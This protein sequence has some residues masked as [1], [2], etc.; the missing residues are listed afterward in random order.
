MNLKKNGKGQRVPSFG[1][2]LYPSILPK[3]FHQNSCFQQEHTMW[4]H[5][6]I[7]KIMIPHIGQFFP[8]QTSLK[9]DNVLLII[10]WQRLPYKVGSFH[11]YSHFAHTRFLLHLWILMKPLYCQSSFGHLRISSEWEIKRS[12]YLFMYIFNFI[13]IQITTDISRS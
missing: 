4:S 3:Q 11:S 1:L 9:L 6:E 5:P 12:R 10:P 2:C 8:N 13:L 7:L